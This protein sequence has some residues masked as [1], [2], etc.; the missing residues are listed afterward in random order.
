MHLS[1]WLPAGF[2]DVKFAGEAAE[3]GLV[4]RP[5]SSMYHASPPPKSGLMLGFGGFSVEHLRKAVLQLRDMLDASKQ[6]KGD[7]KK[8]PRAGDPRAKRPASGPP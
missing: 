1:L 5:I 6:V 8:Q 4:V 2:D 3:S 7:L